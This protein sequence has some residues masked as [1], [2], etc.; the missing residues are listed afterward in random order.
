LA[1]TKKDLILI[2]ST[3][4]WLL[5]VGVGLGMLWDYSISPGVA[6]TPPDRWPEGSSIRPRGD[7]FTLVVVAHPHCPCSRATIG[8]LAAVMARANGPVTAY[9]LF[10]Q[11]A[12]FAEEWVKTDL[13][14]SAAAIPGVTAI[15][16]ERGDEARRFGAETSGQTLLYDRSGLLL[17]SGGITA[18]RGHY[19]DNAGMSAVASLIG[20][21]KSERTGASVF[22]CPLFDPS[23]RCSKAKAPCK[24]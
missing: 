20:S 13:W 15:R 23:S 11:P 17:F 6:G 12:G 19:G 18:A 7:G 10:V 9:V 3:I 16:D 14:R 24:G 4:L 8:E 21:G 2:S 22:G 5:T 1:P